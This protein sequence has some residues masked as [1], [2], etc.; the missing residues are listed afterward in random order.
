MITNCNWNTA[1]A[2]TIDNEYGYDCEDIGDDGEPF[3]YI[4]IL[5]CDGVEICRDMCSYCFK[6]FDCEEIGS[7]MYDEIREQTE[8]AD[9]DS[10]GLYGGGGNHHGNPN[11]QE[12]SVWDKIKKEIKEEKAKTGPS[13][14]KN[15]TRNKFLYEFTKEHITEHVSTINVPSASALGILN[16][17]DFIIAN[18]HTENNE[19]STGIPNHYVQLKGYNGTELKYWTWGETHSSYKN[20]EGIYW[21]L[22]IRK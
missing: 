8:R 18:V 20:A 13:F 9:E 7:H 2:Q 14:F 21:I 19:I 16:Y 5:P 17:D 6:Y 3:T 11:G 22:I 10:F 4:S 1:K 15:I 12:E